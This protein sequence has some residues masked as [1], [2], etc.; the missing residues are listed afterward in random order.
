MTETRDRKPYT[1]L[2]L[3]ILVPGLG[4]G[5]AG[6]KRS[7]GMV[8]M[9]VT[10]LFALGLAFAGY[11]VYAFS[12]SLFAG[13]PILEWL[14][15]HLLPEAGNFVETMLAW[16]LQPEATVE[17]H[18]LFRL[19]VSTEHLGLALTGCAGYVNVILAADASWLVARGALEDERRRSYP[20]RPAISCFLAWLLPGLGHVREGRKSVGLLVGGSILSL[21]VLGLY[22]SGFTGCDRAQLYWWWAGEC[23]AG[24]PT[25]VSSLL[26]GPLPMDRELPDMDLGITLL[27]VAGMLNI[28]SITD[29]YSL[30]EKNARANSLG[31]DANAAGRVETAGDS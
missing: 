24:G 19:P 10:S 1:A 12:S 4:H 29:V 9:F 18:R 14:P 6:D 16:I 27:F 20:G 17:R 11:R 3:G 30:G 13:V 8:F 31:A 21:W 2:L 22:F 25:F 5:Y 7:A 23:G 28:V 15:I 26:F